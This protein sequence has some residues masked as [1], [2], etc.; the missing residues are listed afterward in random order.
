MK[1]IIAGIVGFILGAG[2]SVGVLA[3]T[4]KLSGGADRAEIEAVVK[5]FIEEHPDLIIES[6]QKW[7][8]GQTSGQVEKAKETLKEKED[9]LYRSKY[10]GSI[11]PKD[12]DVTIVEFFDY[13]CP[14]CRMMFKSLDQ[15][16]KKD[17]NLRVVFKEMPIF[18]KASSEN[19]KIGMAVALIAPEKYFAFHEKIMSQEARLMPEQVL[20]IAVK[21]GI[22][23]AEITKLTDGDELLPHI[24]ENHQLAAALNIN[25]T[26]GL[27]IGDQVIPSA[28]PAD[29]LARIIKQ[30]REGEKTQ[31]ID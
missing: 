28:V 6:V 15:T 9:A 18:G 25:G 1:P 29:E 4:G 17:K 5:A 26:P 27:V 10:D 22:D 24:A 19:S 23:K 8:Q 30:R 2:A 14:A 31:G 7:Q 16:V 11:G 21:L 3:S 20:D 13:N 12:A